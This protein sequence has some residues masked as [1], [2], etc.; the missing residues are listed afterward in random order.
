[1][2]LSTP[3]LKTR[4]ITSSW[5]H[6][7][8]PCSNTRHLLSLSIWCCS[9]TGESHKKIWRDMDSAYR[10]CFLEL[11]HSLQEYETKIL[12][13]LN[14]HRCHFS[15]V[16]GQMSS[17]LASNPIITVIENAIL[18]FAKKPTNQQMVFQ[19]DYKVL[20]FGVRS[21]MFHIVSYYICVQ[22]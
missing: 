18:D 3:I 9:L 2:N 14:F 20:I 8:C 7:C 16:S 4:T 13:I 5:S 1:M 15:S 22:L 12:A 6:G 19:V 17:R 11:K 21:L 10:H